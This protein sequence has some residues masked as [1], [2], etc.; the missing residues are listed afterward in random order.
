MLKEINRKI[1]LINQK[2]NHFEKKLEHIDK[3]V[4]SVIRRVNRVRWS[5]ISFVTIY[6]SKYCLRIYYLMMFHIPII[7]SFTDASTH[8]FT[9]HRKFWLSFRLR[10]KILLRNTRDE[11]CCAVRSVQH[12]IIWWNGLSMNYLRKKKLLMVNT[13]WKTNER[14]KSK[15]IRLSLDVFRFALSTDFSAAIQA[16]FFQDDDEK[17][18]GFWEYEG[19]MTRGN[20]QRGLIFRRKQT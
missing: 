6:L 20:Q 1:D 10:L 12:Q 16:V 9:R 7:V 11:I 15:V 2:E 5:L 13:T 14:W 18:D 4:G 19:R 17:F 8:E 3:R